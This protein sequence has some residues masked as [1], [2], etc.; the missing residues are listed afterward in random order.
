MVLNGHLRKKE[1]FETS[2]HIMIS[3]WFLFGSYISLILHN[4]LL[5]TSALFSDVSLTIQCGPGSYSCPAGH[6][7]VTGSAAQ[8]PLIC[9]YETM[10]STWYIFWYMQPPSGEITLLVHQSSFGKNTKNGCYSTNF[11]KSAKSIN[12]TISTL[13]GG[14]SKV[15]LC[16]PGTLFEVIIKLNKNPTAQ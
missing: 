9:L 11:Q 15:F 5:T 3:V 2:K 7:H 4:I 10:Q 14:F 13:Y 12:F 6:I 16:S 8:L 1:R